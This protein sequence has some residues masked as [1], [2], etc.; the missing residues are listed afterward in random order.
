LSFLGWNFGLV[1]WSSLI[2][3]VTV[4]I[5]YLLLLLANL[6]RFQKEFNGWISILLVIGGIR[7]GLLLLPINQ[8]NQVV[9]PQP[10]GIIRNIPLIVV[11]LASAYYFL[12]NA[13][14][15]QDREFLWIGIMILLSYVFYLPVILFVQEIPLLG[16]L[17]I[18]KTLAYVAMGLF[19]YKAL[20]QPAGED[21]QVD[22]VGAGLQ[23]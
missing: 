1:G 2:T 21:K 19:A 20:F 11:G 23:G 15:E 10:W 12:K 14:V 13:A 3:A 6:S 9:P 18:P 22:A 8:W 4:T 17:M 16:M 5:F 7:L